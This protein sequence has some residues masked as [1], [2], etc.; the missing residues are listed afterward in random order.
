VMCVVSA[1]LGV[2]L[3]AVLIPAMTP[4]LPG[5]FAGMELRG[6]V[7]LEA[8]AIASVLALLVGALPALRAMRLDIVEALAA[9]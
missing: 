2:A 5:G 6:H 4:H 7:W 1:L 8:F 9:H 3:S